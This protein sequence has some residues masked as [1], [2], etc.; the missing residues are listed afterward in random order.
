M[1]MTELVFLTVEVNYLTELDLGGF[2]GAEK[3]DSFQGPPL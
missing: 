3:I 2:I 1:G